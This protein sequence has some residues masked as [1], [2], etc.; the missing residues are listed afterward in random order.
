MI[1]PKGKES[2]ACDLESSAAS[3]ADSE[4]VNDYVKRKTVNKKVLK[5]KEFTQW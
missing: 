2:P 3:I 5:L 1:N 4:E